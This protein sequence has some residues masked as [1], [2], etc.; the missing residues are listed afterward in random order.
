MDYTTNSQDFVGA[1]CYDAA[2]SADFKFQSIPEDSLAK[3]QG[4]FNF[5]IYKKKDCGRL[6]AH[7]VTN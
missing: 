3:V 4:E 1:D 2:R 6:G 7:F 5:N